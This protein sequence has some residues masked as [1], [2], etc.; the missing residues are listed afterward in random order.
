MQ[1]MGKD[2]FD[3]FGPLLSDIGGALADL[4]GGDPDGVFLYVE[5]GKGWLQ[6]SVYK[7][8]REVVR[9][10]DCSGAPLLDLIEQG[11]RAEPEDRRWSV[12]EYDVK[13]SEFAVA[14]KYPDEVDVE[15]MDPDRRRDALTARY[16]D[17]PVIY[18][19]PPEGAFEL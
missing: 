5:I 10:L 3:T 16:G 8:E 13:G 12:M 11:W 14:F 19:P 4:A 18:P 17:K 2:R 6:P 15:S 7:E 1:K 9:S